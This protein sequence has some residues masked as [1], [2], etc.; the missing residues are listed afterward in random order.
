MELNEVVAGVRLKY[1][2]EILGCR[3]FKA[4]RLARQIV[5]G[6]SSKKFSL[7]WSYGVDLRRAS[8]GNTFKVN[9]HC[10]A[11]G[12]QPRF[13]SF[14]ICFD[15]TKKALIKECRPFIGL[16]GCHLKHKYGGIFLIDVGSDPNDQYFLI[17]FEVV[18][19]EAKDSWSQFIKL[20]I[21][22]IGESKWC[23]IF[24]Q[25]KGLVLV[26]EEEYPGFEHRLCLRHLY[27][28][29]KKK[30]GGGTLFRDLMLVA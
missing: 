23:F 14:Y 29:F 21:E 2:T 30:F 5:E 22:H 1:A 15:G 18:E 13:K 11:P 27:A 24:Y 20:L 7:L 28:N 19:N 6:D 10:R 25:Q 16:D 8:A 17:A 3:A 12:L 26:F 9:I 4:K